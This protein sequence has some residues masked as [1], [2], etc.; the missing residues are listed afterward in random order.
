[1]EPDFYYY[2]PHELLHFVD[3]L[4]EEHGGV[5]GAMGRTGTIEGIIEQID[6]M[7]REFVMPEILPLE[8]WFE[9]VTEKGAGLH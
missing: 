1:M 6:Q 8:G 5:P 9:A 2:T 7:V 4:W 3:R